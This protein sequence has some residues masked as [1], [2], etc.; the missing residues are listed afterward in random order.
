MFES[1]S[2]LELI[3]TSTTSRRNLTLGDQLNVLQF[4][5]LTTGLLEHVKNMEF[6]EAP[7]VEL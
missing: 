5:E 4:L 7:W 3:P 2:S 6:Q 1:R